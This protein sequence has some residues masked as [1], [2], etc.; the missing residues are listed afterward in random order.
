MSRPRKRAAKKVATHITCN[1]TVDGNIIRTV[2][3]LGHGLM[4]GAELDLRSGPGC[5]SALGVFFFSC[6]T[7]SESPTRAPGSVSRDNNF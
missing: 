3:N 1:E 7:G 2:K 4:M 6:K 5:P